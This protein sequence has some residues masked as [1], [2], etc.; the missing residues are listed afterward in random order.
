MQTRRRRDADDRQRLCR[1]MC[2]GGSAPPVSALLLHRGCAPE[3][4]H[5]PSRFACCTEGR[6][7]SAHQAAKPRSDRSGLS[8]PFL[9]QTTHSFFKQ[10]NSLGRQNHRAL[11]AGTKARPRPAS[12]ASRIKPLASSLMLEVAPAK[13]ISRTVAG[14]AFSCCRRHFRSQRVPVGSPGCKAD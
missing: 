8:S 6:R 11:I 10:R 12:S 4:G 9:R 14:S 1:L 7:P 2:G 5:S 3:S 13:L